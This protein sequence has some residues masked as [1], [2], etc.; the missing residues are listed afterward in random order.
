VKWC[1]EEN[2]FLG[3]LDG[4]GGLGLAESYGLWVCRRDGLHMYQ[5]LYRR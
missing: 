2:D 5:L 3:F 1:I 4:G